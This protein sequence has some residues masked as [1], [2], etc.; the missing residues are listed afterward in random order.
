MI[1]S[2][3]AYAATYT[4]TST[5][6][7]GKGSLRWAIAQANSRAGADTIAFAPALM[8]QT[9][10]PTLLLPAI[11][12]P[13]TTIDGDLNDDGAPDVQISGASIASG[14]GLVVR[15]N[16]AV[17]VGLSITGFGSG[18]GLYLD[19]VTDCRVRSCHLGVAL[20]GVTEGHNAGQLRLANS[21]RNRIGGTSAAGRNV[22][23]AGG[24][25]NTASVVLSQSNENTVVGNHI[26]VTR[27]G[28][29]TLAT[30]DAGGWYPFGFQLHTSQRNTIGGTTAAERN[31]FGGLRSVALV[32]GS[33]ANVVRGNY[34][35]LGVDGST[36]LT[37]NYGLVIDGSSSNVVGG[38]DPGAGNVFAGDAAFGVQVWCYSGSAPRADGNVIAGNYFGMNAEGSAHR[39]LKAGVVVDGTGAGPVPGAQTIGG[40]SAASGNWIC[41]R[42]AEGEA[43][44]VVLN[45][46]G[47]GSTI[48]NNVFG[49]FPHKGTT[50][51][52]RTMASA[53]TVNDA[54][55]R[56][57]EN[58]IWR[59]RRGIVVEGTSS[60]E[61]AIMANYFRD[62]RKAVDLHGYALVHMGNLGNASPSDDGGN[63]FVNTL[64]YFIYNHTTTGV[65]AEGNDFG[66]TSAAAIGAKIYDRNDKPTLG[67]V[68]FDPLIGGVH[69]TGR[70][71]GVLALTGASAVSS[72]AGAQLTFTLSAPANVSVTAVNLA[73]RQ[74]KTVCVDRECTA[75][76]NTLL[77]DG[78]TDLG[79]A[80]PAGTYLV[81]IEARATDGAAARALAPLRLGR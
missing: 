47:D 38:A 33:D 21:S 80:A 74:V 60:P 31:L 6:N 12:D 62:C 13:R 44:G 79:L 58:S 61:A 15:G 28:L 51:T 7:V 57:V 72:A 41:P 4:V 67:L 68:D 70:T 54:S 3:T 19:G 22:I 2:C 24:G 81:Q 1:A 48:R 17:I 76:L 46:G 66:T 43:R 73:G 42:N 50:N 55:A 10:A 52:P 71:E 18:I 40:G 75:G 36:T 9:I 11:T 45:R 20:D 30:P 27:D 78:R 32:E 35:G 26:G 59:A 69:P 49:V 63:Q 5:G 53:V 64:E 56:I 23:A 37:M 14:D 34:V 77:W 39:R 65:Q 16:H 29:A 8:G 25:V